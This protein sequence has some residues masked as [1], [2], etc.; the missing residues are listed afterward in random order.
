MHIVC[1]SYCFLWKFNR[2]RPQP[3]APSLP[4]YGFIWLAVKYAHHIAQLALAEASPTVVAV[5]GADLWHVS[6]SIDCLP[7][8]WT[9]RS[10]PPPL[11]R[12][13]LATYR[14]SC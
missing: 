2:A 5:S 13:G 1:R 9:D 7:R 14:H 8:L 12:Q 11:Y 4:K 10:H 6:Y 3:S